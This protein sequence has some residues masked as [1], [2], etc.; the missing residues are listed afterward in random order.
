MRG[1]NAA[2]FVLGERKSKTW[3]HCRSHTSYSRCLI[4][5]ERSLRHWALPCV[6]SCFCQS[7]STVFISWCLY[8]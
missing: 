7:H 4:D 1:G 2:P 5:L 8:S 6:A 3:S